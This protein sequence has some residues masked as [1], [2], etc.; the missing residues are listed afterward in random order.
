MYVCCVCHCVLKLVIVLRGSG[1]TYSLYNM[2]TSPVRALVPVPKVNK[3]TYLVCLAWRIVTV[4][5][6]VCT[7]VVGVSGGNVP[8]L[9]WVSVS[10][11]C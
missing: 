9:T 4:C 6:C 7:H 1:T 3:C 11:A 8:P 10:Y 5:V 2:D